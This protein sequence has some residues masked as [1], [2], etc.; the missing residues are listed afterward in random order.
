MALVVYDRVQETTATTGT[1]S[2]TL[3][4]AVAGY[5]SF[6]V[7]G[8]GNT[9]FYCIINNSQWE[10]GIGTYSTT[11]PTLARTTVLSTST[12]T[13]SPITL[14]GASNVFLT[15]P[16]EKSVNLDSNGNVSALGTI[17]SAVWSAT[18][19]AVASGGTGVTTSASNSANSVV[20]RDANVNIAANNTFNGYT[21]VTAAGL[22]TTMTAASSFYQKLV[23]GSGNQTFKLPDATTLPTGAT[24]IFDND[25]SGNLII[26]DSAGGAIDTIQP[27]S[28]DWIYLEA[29]GTVAGSW[30]QYALIPASY[31]FNTTTA[32]FGNAAITNAT[33]SATAI[34]S[35][36]GGTGLTTFSSSNYALYSTSPSILT[37]G[38]L[39]VLAGG[40][41][42]TTSTGSGSN[43]LNTSPTLVTPT[44]GVASATSLALGSA[45]TV[46]NGGTGITTTPTNGQI[47]IGNGTNY[48]AATLTAGTAIS[49]TNASGSVTVAGAT[50]GVTAGAYTTANIT[51]D[52]QGRVI[53]ASS[54]SGGS[55]VTPTSSATTFYI[56]GTNAT[57]G[58]LTAYISNTNAVSYNASTGALTA[59]SFSG[60][61]TGLTGTAS[62]LSIGGNS[63][64]VTGL[65]RLMS[66]VGEFPT[67][68][69]QDFNNLFGSGYY[70]IVWGN[71]SGTLNTPPASNSY[72]TLLVEGGSN[73]YT[74]T[75][76]PYSSNNPSP[77]IRTYYNGSWG[78]WVTALTTSG[79][80]FSGSLTM[81]GNIAAQ[82]DERL[83]KN[84]RPVQESFVEKLADIKSGIYDRVDQEIS[85]AGVS[86][87]SLQTLLPEAV[88]E[89]EEGMLA[90]NYGGAAL[91]AAIE[92]AKEVKALR[93]EIA[94]L[95]AK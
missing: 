63:G 10:V 74:Q 31:D 76:T 41:G 30:G 44:L 67:A 35:A 89:D 4:G 27:G 33:W 12:G 66:F 81:S 1:G 79:T 55:T 17:T 39:P 82:S 94:A 90:V 8:N 51:V 54:G 3:G 78:S 34:T 15:Y 65:S 28:L 95:K 14:S 71:Y 73:F 20:L 5:Q 47:P 84:W 23:A 70:D 16:A 48:T 40:T 68:N 64:G 88:L 49:I 83:K 32:S 53:S 7:V 37:A 19:I 85:Q 6:A 75:F 21:S 56:V 52:A 57:A 24:Y 36:F 45:L 86:A 80:T 50:S 42:V 72:G 9:T 29:N 87:Q 18:T 43:V 2:L 62:S 93:A 61:G 22:T 69:S 60:A 59:S 91:V 77:C 13:A 58:S 25:S 26:Q 46:A 11:G 38:T 92:L